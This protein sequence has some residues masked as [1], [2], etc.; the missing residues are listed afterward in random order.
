MHA[1]PP[2]A[3]RI[4]R[5]PRVGGEVH[6]RSSMSPGRMRRSTWLGCRARRARPY[7]LLSEAEWEYVARAEARRNTLVG[8]P[9][10][11]MR[12]TGRTADG[13]EQLRCGSMGSRHRW[14]VS[15]RMPLG[16]SIRRVTCGNGW[17]IAGMTVTRVRR[18]MGVRGR[19]G[20]VTGACC[21]AVPGTAIQGTCAQPSASGAS[22]ESATTITASVWPGRWINS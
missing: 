14:E 15:N 6:G 13:C 18:L 4:D 12:I 2:V 3:V 22:P 8:Q 11:A 16:C 1:W 19:A 20:T 5:M 10:M 21:A 17:R 7:R 9:I